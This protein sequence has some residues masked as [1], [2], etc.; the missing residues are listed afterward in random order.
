[1]SQERTE[2][3]PGAFRPMVW[4]SADALMVV[5]EGT[6]EFSLE[7]GIPGSESKAVFPDQTISAGDVAYIP[8]G[9][10]YWFRE[11][12]GKVSAI[13]I[14]VFNVGDW[15]S[16]EMAK[17]LAEQNHI[18]IASNLHVTDAEQLERTVFLS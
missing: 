16:F 1:M 13:T 10:A 2:L 9:R 6:V 17:S 18:A 12:S 15:K 3:A 5:I 14:T 8:N 11:A 7:G 4:T